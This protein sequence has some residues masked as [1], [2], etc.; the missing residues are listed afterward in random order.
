ML[1]LVLTVVISIILLIVSS[2]IAYLSLLALVIEAFA[3]GLWSG[4]G[5]PVLRT[6]LIFAASVIFPL[7]LFPVTAFWLEPNIF[8][9]PFSDETKHFIYWAFALLPYVTYGIPAVFLF[10]S[11]FIKER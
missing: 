8:S 3:S 5:L 1:T 2:V 11:W 4:F 6:F 7:V 9:L 10:H